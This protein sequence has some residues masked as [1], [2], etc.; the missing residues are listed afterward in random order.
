MSA[1]QELY[2]KELEQIRL[3]RSIRQ[4]KSDKTLN[5]K[6][7]EPL[8]AISLSG[9][10]VRSATF[11]TGF[12]NGIAAGGD[13]VLCKVDY[14][15]TV[16][17]GGYFGAFY[18]QLF[19]QNRDFREVA[20]LVKDPA[21][22]EIKYLKRNGRY[23]AKSGDDSFTAAAILIRNLLWLHVMMLMFLVPVF[24]ILHFIQTN[25]SWGLY[26]AYDELAALC[27]PVPLTFWPALM[28]S[29]IYGGLGIA[30]FLTAAKSD[31]L[32]KR[33]LTA[34]LGEVFPW[35]LACWSLPLL[36]QLSEVLVGYKTEDGS[37]LEADFFGFLYAAI[38]AISASVYRIQQKFQ[39]IF[40]VKINAKAFIFGIAILA[41][42]LYLISVSTLVLY[43]I[44]PVD[45]WIQF[46]S[47]FTRPWSWILLIFGMLIVAWLLSTRT[48]SINRTSMH[49]FYAARLR[50]SF[51]GAANPK[52]FAQ[53]DLASA[54]LFRAD[55]DVPDLSKYQPTMHGG[56][57]HLINIT[58]NNSR[59]PESNL[60]WPDCKGQNLTMSSLGYCW[61][62]N[63]RLWS[64]D[65]YLLSKQHKHSTDFRH[66]PTLSAAIAI[67]GAAASTGMGQNTSLASSL[68]TALFNIRTGYWW[69]YAGQT[70]GFYLHYRDELFNNFHAAE[71]HAW[72]LS[73]GGHFENLAVYELLDR[74]VP[75]IIAL[76]AG[77]DP[78]YGF[79]D[80][81]N[82][83]RRAR[84]DLQCELSLVDSVCAR[85][86]FPVLSYQIGALHELKPG[87][88]GSRPIKRA[89]LFKGSWPAEKNRPDVW[90]LYIKPTLT[91]QEPVDVL[92]Y[93]SEHLNFP[94]QST[95]D[96]FFD[97]AQWES[98][99]RLGEV[100]AT[101]LNAG[102]REFFNV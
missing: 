17:G 83:I 23:L 55:D 5:S 85:K 98:Y 7:T 75:R 18:G 94:H 99:R 89:A 60:W 80:L 56:P 36:A 58:L 96:Q 3:S 40:G 11:A 14:L 74:A 10:G 37:S 24:C 91:G 48:A 38:A 4:P 22:K 16:S 35:A 1:L 42:F 13:G 101:E 64:N 69:G 93:Q 67:S 34:M 73:D 81:A 88:P 6:T 30:Y 44:P 31:N 53:A 76:D 45:H 50:Y 39:E 57:F 29:I 97:E 77:C 8:C 15:S 27:A 70:P 52:R 51:L 78:E 46:N 43:S 49:Y 41:A 87:T 84:L 28:L 66:P 19:Q 90:L 21:S 26:K 62:N 68:I 12:F 65:Q 72:Y 33:N 59:A 47:W 102:I 61:G 95:A 92:Q 25:K 2:E 54:S 82:L 100:T 79:G 20:Q 71:K 86:I 63:F 9:G 32:T